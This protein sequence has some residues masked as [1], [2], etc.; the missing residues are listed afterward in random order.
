MRLVDKA[1]FTL[2]ELGDRWQLTARD[3]AYL[4]ENGLL[5]LSVKLFGVSI[6]RGH[7]E[8]VSSEHWARVP[9]ERTWFKGLLD[10]F[11]RDVFRVFREGE[12][13]VN[14]FAVPEPEYCHVAEP[15]ATVLVRREDVLVRREERDRIEAKHGLVRARTVSPPVLNQVNDYREVRTAGLVF[16]LGPVQARVVRLLCEAA[17]TPHPWL[18]GKLALSQAG[19]ASTRMGDLFKSQPHWRRLIESDGRGRYRLCLPQKG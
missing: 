7:Y 14:Q 13:A 15:G 17:S 9:L 1:Y 11:E 2:E 8:G 16:H 18:D 5:R 10:L 3:L 19:S 6:E 12:V 4:A